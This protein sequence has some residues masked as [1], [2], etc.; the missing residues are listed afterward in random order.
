MSTSPEGIYEPDTVDYGLPPHPVSLVDVADVVIG[1]GVTASSLVC[2]VLSGSPSL[3][4]VLVEARD[5]CSG[6]TG[7]NGGYIKAMSPG[8]WFDGKEQYGIREAIQVMENEHSH[9]DEIQS[10]VMHNNIDCDFRLLEGLGVYHDESIFRRTTET[11]D[12]R[13]KAA[14]H[15]S[16]PITQMPAGTIW[17]YQLVTGLFERMVDKYSLHIQANTAVSSAS[18]DQWNRCATVKRRPG[19]IQAHHV[20]H[21]T[22]AWIGHLVPQLR[23]FVSP[24]RANVQRQVPRT[25]STRRNHSYWLRYAE[26]DYDHLIQRPDGA[27]IAATSDD[28]SKENLPHVHLQGTT[29][30]IFNFGRERLDVTH[31]WSGIVAFTQ[32]GNPFDPF[33]GQLPFS[34]KRRQ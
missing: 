33:V 10:C 9:L 17:S 4:V 23:P 24:V 8:V 34:R 7:H 6:A 30:L 5:L 25:L 15:P 14:P 13:R 12:D 3:N 22:N 16:R 1:S 21:A 11:I 29:P 19:D 31:S 20:V 26:K 18:E 28:S 2:T 32:G 27:F